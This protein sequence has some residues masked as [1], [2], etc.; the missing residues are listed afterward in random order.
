MKKKISF[1][2]PTKLKEEFKN[3]TE[4]GKM[5]DTIN[6]LLEN[7]IEE[8]N[9]KEHIIDKKILINTQLKIEIIEEIDR[10]YKTDCEIQTRSDIY[11]KVIK[12]YLKN[13]K[14]L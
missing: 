14:D 2:L 8:Y 5:E 12:E 1:F 3:A 7:F 6:I 9:K 10:I 4:Y 11:I 13:K